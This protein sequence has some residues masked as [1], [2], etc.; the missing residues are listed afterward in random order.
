MPMVKIN[1]IDY[2]VSILSAGDL[3]VLSALFE[4]AG[5]LVTE[6]KPGAVPSLVKLLPLADQL[7][8]TVAHLLDCPR[9][10]VEALAL[11]E[12]IEVV[13][14][15]AAKWMTLNAAYLNDEV[16]P[17][18]QRLSSSLAPLASA[19]EADTKTD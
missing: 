14:Q 16:T 8:T 3:P 10:H 11:H 17:A 1:G 13:E 15:V 12:L 19:A 7:I 6:F 5:P 4:A 2:Q 18:I 9:K